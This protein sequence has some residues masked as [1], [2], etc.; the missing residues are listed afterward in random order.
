MLSRVRDSSGKK[1]AGR[2]TRQ[3][4]R[5]GWEECCRSGDQAAAESRLGRKLQ[6]R[7]TTQQREERELLIVNS[8]IDFRCLNEHA[9]L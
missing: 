6:V 3:R 7:E 1:A 9:V 5:V 2:E 8:E 4:Q